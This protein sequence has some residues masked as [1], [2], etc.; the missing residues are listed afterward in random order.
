M[1]IAKNIE[2]ELFSEATN[3]I[4]GQTYYLKTT[5]N[6]EAIKSKKKKTNKENKCLKT[7]TSLT[8]E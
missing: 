6:K 5:T 2:I 7:N 3:I 4:N 1:L 8:A